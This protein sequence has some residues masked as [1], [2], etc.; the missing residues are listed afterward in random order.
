MI[1]L[2]Q[3]V[4]D[5]LL[6]LFLIVDVGGCAIPPDDLSFCVKQ[7]RRATEVP[8]ISFSDRKQA[9][10]HF[11]GETSLA[12]P[13]PRRRGRPPIVGMDDSFPVGPSDCR[14]LLAPRACIINAAVRAR[15]PNELRQAVG[16]KPEMFFARL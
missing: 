8:S 12:R 11:I 3:E 13:E 16:Q 7:G 5:I 9:V 10:L 1:D 15:R 4:P 6:A 14:I 2:G